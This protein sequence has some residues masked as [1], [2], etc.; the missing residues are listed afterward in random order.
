MR[1]TAGLGR[2]ARVI[3]GGEVGGRKYGRGEGKE[4]EGYEEELVKSADR[5]QHVLFGGKN[6]YMKPQ[7]TGSCTHGADTYLIRIIKVK[8]LRSLLVDLLVTHP[9]PRHCQRSIHVH[10]MAGQI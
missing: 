4:V 6:Q 5:E 2:R 7:V 3:V 1:R 10:V 9:A 8:Q